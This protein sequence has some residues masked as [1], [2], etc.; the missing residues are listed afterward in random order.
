MLEHGGG[1]LL[2]GFA[3]TCHASAN[4]DPASYLRLHAK[5]SMLISLRWKR[6]GSILTRARPPSVLPVLLLPVLLLLQAGG[7][8]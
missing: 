1:G 6:G 3:A 2:L 4:R 5:V 8:A 7:C